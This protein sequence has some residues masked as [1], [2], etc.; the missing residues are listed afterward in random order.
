[1][2]DYLRLLWLGGG[3]SREALKAVQQAVEHELD[4]DEVWGRY[5]PQVRT[6]LMNVANA[7]YAELTKMPKPVCDLI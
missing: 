6:E 4:M 3:I 2:T 7:A 1:M 5:S